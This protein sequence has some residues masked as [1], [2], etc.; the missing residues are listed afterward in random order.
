[1]P[2]ATSMTEAAANTTA[3]ST[4]LAIVAIALALIALPLSL[5][6]PGLPIAPRGTEATW[7]LAALSVAHDHDL[8]L[9]EPDRDRLFREFPFGAERVELVSSDGWQTPLWNVSWLRAVLI[10]P[11]AA[12]LGAN[13]V[14][15]LNMALL[16]AMM[17]L[18]ASSLRRRDPDGPAALLAVPFFLLSPLLYYAFAMSDDLFVAFLVA[19]AVHALWG[20]GAD[21]DDAR[22]WRRALLAGLTVAVAGYARPIVLPLLVP[23]IVAAG[24][25]GGRRGVATLLVTMTLT[26][27]ALVGVSIATTGLA[28]PWFGADH[29]AITASSPADLTIEPPPLQADVTVVPVGGWSDLR[30]VPRPAAGPSRE[31]AWDYLLGRMSGLVV[32]FPFALVALLLFLVNVRRAPAGILLIGAVLLGG[33]LPI[34][35]RSVD[36]YGGPQTIGNRYLMVLYPALLYAIPRARP[37]WLMPFGALAAGALIGPLLLTPFG[38]SAPLG[39]VEAH[40]RGVFHQLFPFEISRLRRLEA[41]A[42]AQ[43]GGVRFHGRRDVTL[44]DDDR[45]WIT[46]GRPIELWLTSKK[47]LDVAVFNAKVLAP[48]IEI[49]LDLGDEETRLQFADVPPEGTTKRIELPVGGGRL[50]WGLDGVRRH[51]YRL[52]ARTSVGEAPA[53]RGSGPEEFLL[54]IG[55]TYLGTRTEIDRDLFA[56]EWHGCDVPETMIAGTSAKVITRVRNASEYT[57]PRAGASQVRLGYHWLRPDGEPHVWDGVRTSLIQDAEAGAVIATFQM[58]EA[59]LEPGRYVLAID[60]VLEH[61]TWFSKRNGDNMCRAEVTIVAPANADDDP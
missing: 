59:P 51:A 32:Y 11:I 10:A 8:I 49:R 21:D 56:V 37:G 46:G 26:V 48:D 38:A 60:P 3:R 17:A 9:G 52:R 19:V 28:A 33:A 54:G 39:S 7:Y 43:H 24:R 22:P 55:L 23:L 30:P 18:G 13:G 1:V 36:W 61:V 34:L 20:A 45:I 53:W 40:A 2:S 5:G 16:A 25:R 31:A 58:I 44:I 42:S 12:E 29:R 4:H 6:K 47:P 35:Y 27:S 14:V 15:A 50:T 57:W 41:Y